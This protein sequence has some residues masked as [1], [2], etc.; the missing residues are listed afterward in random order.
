M[1]FR[2]A[3]G[4]VSAL[5]ISLVTV[6]CDPLDLDD[7]EPSTN[8]DETQSASPTWLVPQCTPSDGSARAI[9]S[10]TELAA[11]LEGAWYLC[12][13]AFSSTDG[14]AGVEFTADHAIDLVAEDTALTKE[15]ALRRSTVLAADRHATLAEEGPERY[16]VELRAVDGATSGLLVRLDER[17]AVLTLTDEASG[18]VATFVRAH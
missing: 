11:E 15:G 18:A 17:S 10:T 1:N 12:S 6:A 7:V 9:A 4:L 3:Q 13:G 14:A 5:L 2:C 8:L 16:R